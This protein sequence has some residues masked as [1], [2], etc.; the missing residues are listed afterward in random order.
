MNGPKGSENE[1]SKVFIRWL[2]DYDTSISHYFAMVYN[3][4]VV[5]FNILEH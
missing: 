3:C 2:L 4:V 1:T 5:L